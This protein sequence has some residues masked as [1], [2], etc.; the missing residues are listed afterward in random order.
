MFLGRS[1]AH[2][3]FLPP[4]SYLLLD[5]SAESSRRKAKEDGDGDG[6]RCD[7]SDLAPRSPDPVFG[8]IRSAWKGKAG[9]V[10]VA[11]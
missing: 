5:Q 4:K 9:Q 2:H 3:L 10:G 11:V 1:W 8:V 7:P 6:I